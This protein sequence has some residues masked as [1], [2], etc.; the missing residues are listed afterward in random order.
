MAAQVDEETPLLPTAEG[1]SIPWFQFSIVLLLLLAEPLSAHII[2]PFAAELIRDV[3]ITHGDETHVGYYVGLLQSLFYLTEA[4]GVLY[5]GRLSD[6]VGRKPIILLGLFGLSISSLLFGLSTTFGMLVLSRCLCGALN[7]NAGVIKTMITELTDTTNLPQLWAYIPFA[8]STGTTIAPVIGGYLSRPAE[9]FPEYF[10]QNEFWKTHP[11]FLPC[12]IPAAFSAFTWIVG[13]YLLKETVKSPVPI[14]HLKKHCADNSVQESQD[15][16]SMHDKPVELRGIF[17]PRIFTAVGNYAFLSLVEIAFRAIQPLFFATPV[18]FGGL[19]LPP[20]T[21]GNILSL[22]GALSGI[23]QVF[24][25]AKIHNHLG[26]KKTFV[27]GVVF[28]APLFLTFPVARILVKARGM[29]TLVW[30][31]IGLQAIL[32][33]GYGL[34]FGAVFMYINAA[35]PDQ[36]SLGATHGFS[37]MSTSIMRAIGPVTASSL[38]SLSSGQNYLGGDLVYYV[39]FVVASVTICFRDFPPMCAPELSDRVSPRIAKS[40]MKK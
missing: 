30:V 39:L 8:W 16:V 37:Q 3:G 5:W 24:L 34:A 6:R 31:I 17:T 7:G 40:H 14:S 4:I 35:S 32:P 28:A 2:Y 19:G 23:V 10:G 33:I 12:V 22:S 11:Y 21:I 13:F 15:F 9:H 38:F 20:S 26:S 27:R 36:A 1:S 29:D 18:E 25:F